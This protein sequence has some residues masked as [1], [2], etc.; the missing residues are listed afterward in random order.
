MGP[1]WPPRGRP[2]SPLVLLFPSPRP[3]GAPLGHLGNPLWPV[4]EPLGLIFLN[5]RPPRAL[6]RGILLDFHKF[7]MKF[8]TIFR[9]KINRFPHT[10]LYH[11]SQI[12][13]I[14]SLSPITIPL[15]SS[16]PPSLQSSNVGTAEC[17]ER[18]NNNTI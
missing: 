14:F 7:S 1:Y 16:N 8:H 13:L 18:L 9:Y 10:P 11:I 12:L 6:P 4:L 2:G 3:S 17:A 15:K 5:L